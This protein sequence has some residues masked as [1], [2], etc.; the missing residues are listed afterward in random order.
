MSFHFS[1][2]EPAA[3][4]AQFGPERGATSKGVV[5]RGNDAR[6]ILGYGHAPD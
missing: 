3:S 4:T 5:P 6:F 1:L 2:S